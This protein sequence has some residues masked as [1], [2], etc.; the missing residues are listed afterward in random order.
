[1]VKDKKQ[2]CFNS[3]IKN[4]DEEEM[5]TWTC[6]HCKKIAKSHRAIQEVNVVKLRLRRLVLKID[7]LWPRKIGFASKK[8]LKSNFCRFNVDF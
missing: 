6:E 5:S 1:M 3:Q 4:N 2:R 7:M 8:F